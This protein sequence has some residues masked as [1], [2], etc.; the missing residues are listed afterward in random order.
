MSVCLSDLFIELKFY[1]SINI[2]KY[3]DK[4]WAGKITADKSI[5]SYRTCP[6]PTVH[7]S[8]ANVICDVIVFK[9]W[10]ESGRNGLDCGWH[11]LGL[12]RRFS[13][14]A[15]HAHPYKIDHF[16]DVVPRQSLRT[17]LKK[18]NLTQ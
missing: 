3:R 13:A 4:H 2:K 9:S 10:T 11:L 8:N 16:R 18:L 7:S 15:W 1:V 14:H 12:G 6:A 5:F 17:V